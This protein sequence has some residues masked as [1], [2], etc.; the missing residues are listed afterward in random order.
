MPITRGKVTP[1]ASSTGVRAAEIP[2]GEPLLARN[3]AARRLPA[4]GLD[5]EMERTIHLEDMNESAAA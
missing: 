2:L 5:R 3:G 4:I 1:S